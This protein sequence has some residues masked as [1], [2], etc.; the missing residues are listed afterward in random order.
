M[1][2]EIREGGGPPEKEIFPNLDKFVLSL[3]RKEGGRGEEG[4]GGGEETGEGM[5]ELRGPIPLSSWGVRAHEVLVIGRREEG[6]EEEEGKGVEGERKKK[7]EE[8][9]IGLKYVLAVDPVPPFP[10]LSI[11][12]SEVCRGVR[13]RM[14][15]RRDSF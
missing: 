8:K 12:V 5:M 7:K 15:G 14:G 1:R 9:V 11:G 10:L 4:E 6:E 13:M 2:G 3:K